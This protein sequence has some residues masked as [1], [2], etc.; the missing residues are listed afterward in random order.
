MHRAVQFDRP[1]RHVLVGLRPPI[2]SILVYLVYSAYFVYFTRANRFSRLGR[3]DRF[4]RVN[5]F[6]RVDRVD[7][8]IRVD[9]FNRR[10]RFNR[11]SSP[12]GCS[13]VR[14]LATTSLRLIAFLRA[15]LCRP[16]G[17]WANVS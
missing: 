12:A 6:N 2:S 17:S 14:V 11:L 13:G 5:R 15:A 10:D 9:R 1:S 7:R 3:V 4:N 16:A 8:F